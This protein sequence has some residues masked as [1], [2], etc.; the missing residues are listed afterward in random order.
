MP[1]I[2][3]DQVYAHLNMDQPD[4]NDVPELQRFIDA[5]VDAIEGFTRLTVDPQNMVEVVTVPPSGVVVLRN[6]PVMSI[7]DLQAVDGSNTQWNPSDAVIDPDTGI[8]RLAP[9]GVSGDVRI[10]YV[11]GIGDPPASFR[12]AGL[13][14]VAHLWQTQR[15]P[16]SGRRAFGGGADNGTLESGAGWAIPRAASDLLPAAAPLMP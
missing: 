2:T 3:L 9:V 7:A 15:I 10:T 5:A 1:L 14:I 11:A 12:V 6:R 4:P 16:L 13:I 8:V